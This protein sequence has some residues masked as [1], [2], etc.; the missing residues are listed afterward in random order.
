VDTHACQRP[1]PRK[2]TYWSHLVTMLAGQWS[3]RKNLRDLVIS[4]NRQ[5]RTC[6]HLGLAAVP[7]STLATA[8][9]QHPAVICAKTFYKLY[10]R[11][12]AELASQP[13]KAP[14]IKIIDSTTKVRWGL[15]EFTRLAQTMLLEDL[16]LWALLGLRPSNNRQPWLFNEHAGQR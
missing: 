13:Q 4:V 9:H 3:A 15:L 14:K 16:D 2:S 8:N 1:N 12:S 10:E 6:Y 11:P 5:V 7:R